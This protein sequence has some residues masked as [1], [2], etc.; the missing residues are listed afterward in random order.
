VP[1]WEAL[2]PHG[3]VDKVGMSPSGVGAGCATKKVVDGGGGV[4]ARPCRCSYKG[5][6]KWRP[7]IRSR[8]PS[9]C[10]LWRRRSLAVER[11]A[12][13]GRW[14]QTVSLVAAVRKATGGVGAEAMRSKQCGH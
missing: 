2:L 1:P 4:M 11:Q 7:S 5:R 12:W 10:H 14:N 9:V 3:L 8:T 13:R 6:H